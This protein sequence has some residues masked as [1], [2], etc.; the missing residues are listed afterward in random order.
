[1][2]TVPSLLRDALRTQRELEKKLDG[3]AALLGQLDSVLERRDSVSK[4][5]ALFAEDRV[6]TV[7]GEPYMRRGFALREWAKCVAQSRELMDLA[8]QLWPDQ[9]RNLGRRQKALASRELSAVRWG[10]AVGLDPYESW[11][12]LLSEVEEFERRDPTFAPSA[13]SELPAG[14]PFD[15]RLGGALDHLGSLRDSTLLRHLDYQDGKHTIRSPSLG[16]VRARENNTWES[17]VTRSLFPEPYER[18]KLAYHL[19]HFRGRNLLFP[20]LRIGGASVAQLYD[21]LFLSENTMDYGHMNEHA[22]RVIASCKLPSDELHNLNGILERLNSA[23]R[24]IDLG[25]LLGNLGSG[26]GGSYLGNSLPINLIPSDN[27]GSCHSLMLAFVTKAGKRGK[28]SWPAVMKEL[29]IHLTR[30]DQTRLVVVVTNNWDSEVFF[31]EY[32]AE[33]AAHHDRGRR[34]LFLLTGKLPM[35]GL[36]PIT[37]DFEARP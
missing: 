35:R 27:R 12:S 11:R 16:K 26:G 2:P 31:E 9:E 32:F 13:L 30:C 4:Q 37:V 19:R 23:L 17:E 20:W 1:M 10:A 22:Q 29:R 14:V 21:W 36:S 3:L 7:K 24:E 34:F 15:Q 5:S 8:L 25:E 6:L 33:L 18:R 28:L